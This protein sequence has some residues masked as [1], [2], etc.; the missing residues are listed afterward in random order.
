MRLESTKGKCVDEFPSALW[1]IKTS[2][3]GSTNE[4]PFFI[5]LLNWSYNPYKNKSSNF[6]ISCCR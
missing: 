2:P 4:E 3:R 6:E 5:S 1:A